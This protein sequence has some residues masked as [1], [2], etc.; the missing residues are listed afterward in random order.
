MTE[1][2]TEDEILKLIRFVDRN[3]SNMFRWFDALIGDMLFPFLA[4]AVFFGVIWVFLVFS[5][6][7]QV[8]IIIIGTSLLALTVGFFSLFVH[9]LEENIVKVNFKR[10]EKFVEENEK[11]LLKALI[12]MKVKHR[13]FN[14]EQIYRMNKDM[15][16]RTRLL[17][18]LYE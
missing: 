10:F 4:F 11:P 18:T 1:H 8:D 2:E 12:K 13:E 6:L 15:F 14:L 16:D 17:E 7:H 3:K 9:F 5:S